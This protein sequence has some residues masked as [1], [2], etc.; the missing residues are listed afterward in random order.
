MPSP[1]EYP[2]KDNT[3][4]PPASMP[5]PTHEPA[6]SMYVLQPPPEPTVEF[7]RQSYSPSPIIM[8]LPPAESVISKSAVLPMIVIA[9]KLTSQVLQG[10]AEDAVSVQPWGAPNFSTAC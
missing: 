1:E 6:E 10:N 9:H 5:L 4:L 8:P 3:P 7:Q 2:A